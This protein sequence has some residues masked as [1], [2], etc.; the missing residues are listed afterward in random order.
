MKMKPV[1]FKA[2]AGCPNPSACSAAGKC[3][4]GG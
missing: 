4:G 1:K 2:C 3:M